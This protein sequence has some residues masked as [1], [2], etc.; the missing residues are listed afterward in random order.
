MCEVGQMCEVGDSRD[1]WEKWEKPRS[2]K[3]G[4]CC[5]DPNQLLLSENTYPVLPDVPDFFKRSQKS[6]FL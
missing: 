1:E 3:Q 2:S 5:V 6:R 4:S